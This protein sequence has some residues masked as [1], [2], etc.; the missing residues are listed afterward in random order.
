MELMCVC[1]ESQG[2]IIEPARH[3]ASSPSIKGEE[4]QN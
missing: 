4:Q 2:G 1:I 3:R